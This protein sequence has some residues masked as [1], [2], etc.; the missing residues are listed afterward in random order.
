M[1]RSLTDRYFEHGQRYL[2]VFTEMQAET[3]DP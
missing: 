2:E 1:I 3:E